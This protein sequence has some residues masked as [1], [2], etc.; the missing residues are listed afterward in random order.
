M[1]FL[2]TCRNREESA[3]RKWTYSAVLRIVEHVV[4]KKIAFHNPAE[5]AEVG[6]ANVIRSF[7]L[8]KIHYGNMLLF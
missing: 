5:A 7:S 8:L 4:L 2:F 3:A 6:K 1:E